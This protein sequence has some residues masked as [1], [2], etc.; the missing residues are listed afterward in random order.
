MNVFVLCTGRCGS[1]TF[2]A[3]CKHNITNYTASHESGPF[4]TTQFLDDLVFHYPP[5]H[6]EVDNALTLFA[7]ILARQYGSGAYFV[8]LLRNADDCIDS[9]AQRRCSRRMYG[10]LFGKKAAPKHTERRRANVYYRV[11]NSILER[12]MDGVSG[13]T[14]HIETP[15]R[16][17]SEMW[18]S[19]GAEGDYDKALRDLGK[20]LNKRP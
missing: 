15:E 10:L 5:N 12:L 4:R 2:A 11:C 6:I 16:G 19:I 8:H 18:E 20:H 13:T 9:L 7:P 17:F 3:A 14:V 1:K